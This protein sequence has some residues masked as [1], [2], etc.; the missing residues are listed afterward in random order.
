MEKQILFSYQVTEQEQDKMLKQILQGRFAFSRN[1]IRRCKHKGLVT[2]NGKVIYYTARLTKGDQIDV[3]KEE[4]RET[5]IIPEPM[6]LKIIY[7][8]LDLLVLDK[9]PGVVVHPTRGHPTGTI[10]NGVAAYFHQKGEQASVHLVNRLD[11]DTSGLMVIAKH[12]FAHSFLAKQLQK[13]QYIRTYLAIVDGVMK[14]ER[15]TIDVPIGLAPHS[16]IQRMVRADAEGKSAVTHYTVCE[17][18]HGATMIKLQLETGRT[19][20]IR[21][22]LAHLGHPLLGDQLY[23]E[24][25]DHGIARQALHASQIELIHPRE[26]N[27]K[28]WSAFFPEDIM[29]LYHRLRII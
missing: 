6:D 3:Y 2:V 22:H 16:G 5:S 1:M 23:G 10:L 20:Q 7:E 21:V 13:K 4:P 18:L 9:P 11:K 19:H 27:Q 28:K 15:G 12:P 29:K 17:R 26:K 8:D 14:E 24:P 25:L